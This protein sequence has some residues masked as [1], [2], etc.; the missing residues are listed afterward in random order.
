MTDV[1]S[2]ETST[3]E[4]T[5]TDASIEYC[6]EWF[7]LDRNKPFDIGRDADLDIDDNQYLHRRFLQIAYIDGL[8]WLINVGSRLSASISDATGSMQ[9]WLAP[10]ARLPVV[11]GLTSVVFTAGPTTYEFVVHTST[12][13]FVDSKPVSSSDGTTTVGAVTFTRS[14]WLLILALSE[15]MLKREGTGTSEIP[16]SAAAAER[17][18]WVLSRFNR[19]LDNVCDK[20]S[21]QGVDGLRGGVGALA[22]NRRARLVEYAVLSRLVTPADLPALDDDTADT[23]QAPA[24]TPSKDAR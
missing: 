10:G 12:P 9:A 14:Q 15:P 3:T 1:S 8:W 20:L 4:S 6:G 21:R 23:P 13:A 11:F 16:S 24:A 18:G 2:S 17:L 5:T 7:T 22:T 19:K